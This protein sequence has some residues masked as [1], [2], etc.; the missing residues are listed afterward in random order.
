M[1]RSFTSFK[2]CSFRFFYLLTHLMTCSRLFIGRDFQE[3]SRRGLH[4]VF[5]ADCVQTATSEVLN[6]R[7]P[8]RFRYCVFD[9]QPLCLS[10]SIRGSGRQR[11]SRPGSSSRPHLRRPTSHSTS[12]SSS[13]RSRA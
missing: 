1:K 3:A 10:T 4:T 7:N 6:I 5:V 2:L 11:I 8:T 9:I 12:R 13:T